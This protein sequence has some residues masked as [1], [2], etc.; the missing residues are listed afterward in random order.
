MQPTPD[1]IKADMA[2]TPDAFSS[3]PAS[4]NDSAGTAASG[5]GKLLYFGTITPNIVVGNGVT[6]QLTTASVITE[7]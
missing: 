3:I 5:T 2:T 4:G 7:T 6:P 1:Q